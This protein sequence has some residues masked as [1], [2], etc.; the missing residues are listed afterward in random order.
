MREFAADVDV[1]RVRIKRITRDQHSFEQL[2]WIVVNDVAILECARLGFIGVAD[3][4]HRPFFVRFDETPFQAAGKSGASA[5]AQPEFLTL[6][7]MSARERVNAC[8]SCS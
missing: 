2:M 1:G 5:S 3:Q 6:L 8:F 7:T 4:I